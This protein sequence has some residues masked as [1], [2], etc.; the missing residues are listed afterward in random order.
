MTTAVAAG[1]LAATPAQAAEPALY[2]VLINNNGLV[3]MG[4]GGSETATFPVVAN[5]SPDIATIRG[6]IVTYGANFSDDLEEVPGSENNMVCVP[7]RQG[8]AQSCTGTAILDQRQMT[9]DLAGRALHLRITGYTKDNQPYVLQEGHATVSRLQKATRLAPADATPEPVRKGARLTVTG[10]LT[11]PDWGN[12]DASGHTRIVGYAG[13]SVYLT[14]AKY[15]SA[16]AYTRIKTVTSGP[17]G[18]LRTTVPATASGA[19]KWIYWGNT[20]AA[21]TS[22]LPDTVTLYK[23]AK[24]T[25]NASPEPVKKGGKLTVTGRLTRATTDAATKFVG[26]GK[27]PVRL[28]FRKANGTYQTVKTVWTDARGYLR[29]T[30]KAK[31]SGYW[32]WSYAGSSAVA[33]VSATGDKVAL[34]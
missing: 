12:L 3:H 25:V 21:S 26:Y 18:A 13:Q 4:V 32:R 8:T 20:G 31:A 15:A 11:A 16:G 30:T 9:N 19:W 7:I 14:Y 23:V 24:L 6:Q 17:D 33:S 22:S 29:T 10:R 2:S 5:V 34:K 1:L 27:Q 28:Q